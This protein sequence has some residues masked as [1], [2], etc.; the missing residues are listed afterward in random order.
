MKHSWIKAEINVVLVMALSGLVCI[1]TTKEETTFRSVKSIT[2]T[3]TMLV[4]EMNSGKNEL[5]GADDSAVVNEE[6]GEGWTLI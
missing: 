6:E 1:T 3:R 4:N 5:V 2:D